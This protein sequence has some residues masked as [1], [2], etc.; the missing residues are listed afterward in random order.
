MIHMGLNKLKP[1][2]VANQRLNVKLDKLGI[3]CWLLPFSLSAITKMMV[4][5]PG[6]VIDN[7]HRF[8]DVGVGGVAHRLEAHA[9]EPHHRFAQWQAVLQRQAKRTAKPLD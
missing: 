2:L 3:V 8:G 7:A 4:Q 1:R 6:D 5:V 9:L